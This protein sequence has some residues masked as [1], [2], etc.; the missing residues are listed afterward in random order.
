MTLIRNLF[1]P[2]ILYDCA[3]AVCR[4]FLA[5][6]SELYAQAA[7][8]TV[9]AEILGLFYRRSVSGTGK[10]QKKPT[11]NRYSAVRLTVYLILEGISSCIFLNLLM[12]MTGF[13]QWFSGYESVSEILFE[14]PLRIQLIAMGFLIPAAEELI[15]RGFAFRALRETYSFFAAAVIS[16]LIFGIYHGNV[17]QAVYAFGM[18][19]LLAWCY[20]RCGTILAP[21]VVHGAANITAILGE[22]GAGEAAPGILSAGRE[23][24]LLIISGVILVC[25]FWG[26]RAESSKNMNK[27]K[28]SL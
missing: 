13:L 12:E 17:A 20:E 15:F 9:T 16:S 19:F 18:A 14:P 25:A 22:R 23:A 26:I 4:C 3:V 1:Y 21:L 27:Q 7:A 24:A 11:K 2:L 6:Y 5:S 28:N 8:A 10:A